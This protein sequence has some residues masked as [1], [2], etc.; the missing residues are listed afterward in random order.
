TAKPLFIG[1]IP[2]AASKKNIGT[3]LASQ[4]LTASKCCPI[5][6][7]GVSYLNGHPLVADRSLLRL[8]NVQSEA[9]I[10]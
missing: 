7:F 1:S 5:G 3:S 9:E 6:D 2:I 8:Q 4:I 10:E